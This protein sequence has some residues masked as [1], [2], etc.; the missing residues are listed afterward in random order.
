MN[1]RLRSLLAAAAALLLWA[2]H[3]P[4]QRHLGGHLG[5]RG[6]A[7]ASVNARPHAAARPSVA[8]RPAAD[9]RR[10]DVDRNRRDV[11]R[12]I[13]VD[14][15]REVDRDIDIHKEIDV[16]H[17]GG[18]YDDDDGCCDHPVAAAAAIA[19][20][21]ATTAAVATAATIGSVVSTLPAACVT[22][23]V[24]GITYEVCDGAWYAPR[25]EGTETTYVVVAPPA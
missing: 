5:T 10:I 13:D 25:F 6:A 22:R 1:T 12:D 11:R 3:L 20:A 19:T 2:E 9:G 7:R 8:P 17:H 4:A 21:A 15:R 16:N 23:V 24:N 18:W 14:R